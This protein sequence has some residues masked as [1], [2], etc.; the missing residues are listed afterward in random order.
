MQYGE[1]RYYLRLRVHDEIRTLAMVSLYGPPDSRLLE[2][3]MDTVWSC[4]PGGDESL[5]LIDVQLIEAVV[6]MVPHPEP[7]APREGLVDTRG[8]FC[9]VE[10]PGLEVAVLGGIEESMGDTDEME[11]TVMGGSE[12]SQVVA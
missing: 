11:E 3:S 8:R 1:V 2:I 12:Y 6:A 4:Q 5:T 9:V 7:I 10:K